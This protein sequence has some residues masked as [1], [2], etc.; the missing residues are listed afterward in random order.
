MNR[1]EASKTRRSVSILWTAIFVAIALPAVGQ[2]SSDLIQ[3]TVLHTNDEH[4]QLLPLRA[5]WRDPENPPMEGGAVAMAAAVAEFRRRD[6]DTLLLSAGDWFQ[7]TPEGTMSFGAMMMSF[8]NAVGYDAAVVGNHEFDFGET[9]VRDLARSAHFR[10][11]GANV[12]GPDKKTLRPYLQPS[13]IIVR[14]GIK[15]GIAGLCTEETAKLVIRERLGEIN[16]RSAV[17]TA[18]ETA[19]ELKRNGADIVIFTNHMGPKEN[20]EL[21]DATSDIDVLIGGH[22]HS[23]VLWEGRP[24]KNALIA[25]CG[26]NLRSMGV[27]D[28]V[29][30]KKAKKLVQK[31]AFVHELRS[32][33]KARHPVV[34]AIIEKEGVAV[35]KEMNRRVGIFELKTAVRRDSARDQSG[36]LGSWMADAMRLAAD[37]EIGIM[38]EGGIRKDLSPGPLTIRDFWELMPFDNTVV[39]VEMT[40]TQIL[41]MLEASLKTASSGLE[42]SGMTVAILERPEA[43]P[44]VFQVTIGGKP[45]DPGKLY[46]L[47]TNSFLADG[48][49]GYPIFRDAKSAKHL[50]LLLRDLLMRDILN[51]RVFPEKIETRWIV[52]PKKKT[53]APAHAH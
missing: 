17:E 31:T 26:A 14:K 9:V 34:E 10:V 7:G 42:L 23:A 18:R 2:S 30:D 53:E 40:G 4:G 38:N 28:L 43:K 37:A 15:I 29:W 49:D 45:L 48:G 24:T 19:A 22:V 44:T 25:Q 16:F 41:A 6:P 21:A 3:L 51:R 52:D 36:A 1:A 27:I 50:D 13:T 33:E 8:M 35:A 47:A 46:T 32:P 5:V 12:V 11:L 20:V 39:R